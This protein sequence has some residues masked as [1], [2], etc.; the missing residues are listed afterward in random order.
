MTR[1]F[2]DANIYFCGFF[3]KEGASAV[4][5][6]LARRKKLN[7]IASHLVLLEADRNLRRKTTRKTVKAFHRFLKE[8]K[9]EVVP[10]PE[11]KILKRYESYIH[12]KDVPVLT[13]ACEAKAQYLITLDR[14]HFLRDEVLSC[15]H[16]IKILTPGDFLHLYLQ[17][18]V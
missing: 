6:K 3:S 10:P 18:K 9:I 14:K 11:D 15:A 2:L 4:I 5:L 8:T 13:A 12:P 1:V 7:L 17:M 16:K